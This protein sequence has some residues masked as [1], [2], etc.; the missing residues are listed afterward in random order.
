MKKYIYLLGLALAMSGCEDFL[1]RDNPTGITDKDFWKTSNQVEAALGL[2]YNFPHGTHHYTPPYLSIVHQEGMTDNSYH[3]A[4]YEGWIVS[5]GNGTVTA[6]NGK[7]SEIWSSRY[8]TIRKCCRLLENMDK[9]YFVDEPERE[10]IRG[11]AIILRVYYHWE[12]MKYFGLEEGIPIVDH[13]LTPKENFMA[14]SSAKA[15]YD[16]MLSELDR[17]IAIKD[18]P[19]KYDDS[20]KSKVDRSVAYALKAIIALNAKRYDVAKDAAKFIVDSGEYELYY[21]TQTDNQKGK[22]F[23]DLFRSVG[24]NNKERILYVPSG[25]REAFFRCAGPGLGQQCT[26]SPLLSF[27]NSFETMQ[28]KTLQELGK[29][30][31]DIY[32][33]NPFYHNNRDPRLFLSVIVPGDNTTFTGY[34]YKPFAEGPEAIGRPNASRTGF[35]LKKYIDPLD[36]NKPYNGSNAFYLIRYAEILLTYAEAL[37][38]SGDWQNP[39]VLKCINAIRKRADMIEVTA[40]Q[41]NS[42]VKVRELLRRERRV[43]LAFE[44]S[45]YLDIRRWGIA[46]DVMDGPT[47]GAINPDTDKPV[48]VEI[49]IFKEGKNE[50]FPIPQSEIIANENMTQNKGYFG[51]E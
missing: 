41:F 25:L 18:L 46:K 4:D 28:G 17:A 23:R 11:E 40:A 32:S 51:N 15:V 7:M 20:R 30:S 38:E 6:E 29:D 31:I 47:F 34:T 19:F 45:R 10:K 21:T 44:G 36:R 8:S 2:C 16:W 42:Q 35:M 49:R 37:I 5:I 50:A 13:S 48:Q 14:R 3:S 43:E 12:L 33:R 24:Q 9:A 26:V 27:V 1:T 39:Q 22:N